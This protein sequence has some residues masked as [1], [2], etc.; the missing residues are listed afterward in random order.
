MLGGQPD[1]YGIYGFALYCI[2]PWDILHIF[3]LTQSI[4]CIYLTQE[5]HRVSEVRQENITELSKRPGLTVLGIYSSEPQVAD[6]K[7]LVNKPVVL[8]KGA[9][10]Q[11]WSLSNGTDQE[12]KKKKKKENN[13]NKTNASS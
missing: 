1:P 11:S 6:C 5:M 7:F 2:V 3:Y 4:Q 8:R 10:L 13:V 9:I 12:K